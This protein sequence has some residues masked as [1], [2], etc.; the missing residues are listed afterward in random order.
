MFCFIV[1][2]LPCKTLRSAGDAINTATTIMIAMFNKGDKVVVKTVRSASSVG[3]LGS[4]RKVSIVMHRN[5]EFVYYTDS[6]LGTD[7]AWF[8]EDEL[9]SAKA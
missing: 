1:L 2:S 6:V 8:F 3:Y 4:L 5:G 9:T 7:G